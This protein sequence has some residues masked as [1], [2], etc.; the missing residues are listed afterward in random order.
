MSGY[1]RYKENS[2]YS[3]SGPELL[4]LI[5]DEAIKRLTRAEI[6]L[7]DK[8]YAD[9]EDC[10]TRTSKIVRYLKEILDMSQ[11][12]SYDLRR[13]YEYLIF[14]LSRVK[15]GRERRRDEIGRIR[16][17]LSEL[18]EA[19]EGANKQVND[20]HMVKETEIRG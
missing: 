7:D 13:I 9:F 16:H 2:I 3:M 12:I 14:D 8:N 18:K 6:S 4:F 19:F 17:I 11:P 5:Y 15:A 1:N 10:L 20:M